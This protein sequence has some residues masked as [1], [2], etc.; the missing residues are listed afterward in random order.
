[1]SVSSWQGKLELWFE[2]HDGKTR[3][4]RRR[5]SGPLA[6]QRPFHPE[7]DGTAHAYLLHPP[8]GIAGGDRLAIECQ[9]AA[10]AR[11]L[12]TTPGATKFYRN[13]AKPSEQT[14]RITVAAGASCEYL[15]QETIVFDG[16]YAS[17]KTRVSLAA[18]SIYIGWD[19][20]SLG[21][22]AAGE[23]YASGTFE[24]SVEI[25]RDDAPIWFERLIVP[26]SRLAA[27]LAFVLAGKPILGTMVYA[28]PLVENLDER[29]RDALGK[30]ARTVFSI[31]QL[32]RVLVCR[33]LGERMSEGKSL[34]RR[35]WEVLRE[36]GIGKSV[37]APR[38]WAT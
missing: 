12:L 25:V 33:Y 37:V 24:Q 6:I 9:L 8:G 4:M 10:G 32:E 17:M 26:G 1:M 29:L 34:F 22:P 15:P 30:P 31:S 11:A 35:A 20:V 27:E 18:D 16:A 19:F 23:R 14:V 36:A 21:R 7:A 13:D 28:G 5:H 3:L 2:H 38:I